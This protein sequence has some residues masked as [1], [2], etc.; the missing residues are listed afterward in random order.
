[1][2]SCEYCGNEFSSEHGLNTHKSMV[3]DAN[4]VSCFSCGNDVKKALNKIERDDRHF[5]SNECKN[6]WMRSLTGE[7]SFAWKGGPIHKNCE[8]C[9]KKYTIKQSESDNSRFCS[10]DCMSLWKSENWRG[11]DCPNWDGGHQ[12]SY[13]PMWNS[14]REG[15]RERDECCKL[16]GMGIKEHE[17]EYGRK[18]DVHHIEPI[19]SFDSFEEANDKSNL[20]MLCRD[21]HAKVEAD[22]K[23]IES[24]TPSE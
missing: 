9:D 3:H 5:C 19:K 13:G 17:D 23:E 20:V 10:L 22:K 2:L 4:I 1:M 6:V 18:P 16:C 11:S 12:K 24:V 21:C 14:I 7:E 8:F 15:I